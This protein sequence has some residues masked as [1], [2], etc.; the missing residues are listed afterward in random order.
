M[1]EKYIVHGKS[2]Y[3]IMP[4]DKIWGE[5]KQNNYKIVN[6]WTHSSNNE[7]FNQKGMRNFIK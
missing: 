5:E 6:E 7:K 1:E 2:V 4:I 3:P